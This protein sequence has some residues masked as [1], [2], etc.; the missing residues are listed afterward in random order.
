MGVARSALVFASL[1]TA[2][3]S[4]HEALAQSA[5][6]MFFEGDMV[7]AQACVLNNRFRHNEGVVWRIR[8]LDAKTGK[9]LDNNGLKSL[10]VELPDGKT[11]P[12]KYGSHPRGAGDDFFWSISWKVPE[13]YPTGTFAYTIVATDLGGQATRW[14]P[15]NVKNS[16]L[17]VVDD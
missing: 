5:P 2:I 14:Q 3:V 4:T 11:I 6:K 15:F 16:Q 9:Q 13:N 7:L 1:F 8:V 17:T 12:M 10:V